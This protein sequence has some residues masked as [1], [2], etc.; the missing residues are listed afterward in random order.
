MSTSGKRPNERRWPFR[1]FEFVT[2]D[3]LRDRKLMLPKK[4]RK[5]LVLMMQGDNGGS[6]LRWNRPATVFVVKEGGV[7]WE[8]EL[9]N[10]EEQGGRLWLRKGFHEFAVFYS[11]THRH[12]LRFKHL[13]DFTFS[14]RIHDGSASE[15][16][17][18]ADDR[19]PESLP[20]DNSSDSDE[21]DSDFEVSHGRESQSQ[22][23]SYGKKKKKNKNE[24]KQNIRNGAPAG[25]D[26]P[27]EPEKT[28]YNSSALAP[29][30][31]VTITKTYMALGQAHIPV[32]FSERYM[33]KE[34]EMV[35]VKVGNGKKVWEMNLSRLGKTKNSAR[36]T[37]G[38]TQFVRDNH[39]QVG[40]VCIFNLL[41]A[42]TAVAL[43][44]VTIL[45]NLD[46]F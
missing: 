2:N 24:T 8:M 10:D 11:L 4:L 31:R 35:R 40:N 9:W 21:E 36:I 6:D 43:F 14:V 22:R 34:T 27:E 37:S 29:S 3:S 44:R 41:N 1:F 13:K 16:E 32:S 12:L 30:F 5:R 18:P 25:Y 19:G 38:W 33:A 26:N 46:I 28:T 42:T 17:Y 23:R 20:D 7:S 15:I 39:L 45:R